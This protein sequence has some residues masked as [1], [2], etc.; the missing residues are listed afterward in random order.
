MSKGSKLRESETARER[1]AMRLEQVFPKEEG[2]RRN[3]T[4]E[5]D[6]GFL[7]YSA[8]LLTSLWFPEPSGYLCNPRHSPVDRM[9]RKGTVKLDTHTHKHNTEL[10]SI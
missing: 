1:E 6:R 7:T 4:R 8:F 5:T 9:L 3:G 10:G 2:T